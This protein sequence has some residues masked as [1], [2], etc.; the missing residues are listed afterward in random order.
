MRM[1]PELAYLHGKPMSTGI[2]KANQQDF[3]VFEQL[4]FT[5][6]GEGEH[7][8]IH[9]RKTGGNTVF[10]ARALAKYF[11]VKEQLVSYA[12]LKDRFAVTEQWFG[13][14]L[15]GKQTYDLSDLTIEGVEILSYKRHNKKLRTGALTGNR[16]ELVIREVTNLKDLYERWERV[17]REGVPNYFGEQRFGID[18]GNIEAALSLFS[19]TKV[20]DKKK[21]GIY[22][23][24]ARSVIFNDIINERIKHKTFSTLAVGD[25][26]MLSG[27]Q[28][29]FC[30]ENLD[31]VINQ[32]LNNKDIDITASMWG[33]GE[34][35]SAGQTREFEQQIAER[36]SAFSQGLPR[37]GLKQERRRI[38]LSI[39]DPDIKVLPNHSESTSSLPN[40][41]ISF[42]LAAGS[43]ATTV[44]R[45]LID[46]Q[47][48]SVRHN[49][50]NNV[51]S[52]T[53]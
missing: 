42:S 52:K 21:R 31:D 49:V 5:P 35:M 14:H 20:K 1:L 40:V 19:G 11:K 17:V 24:A 10:V 45:E 48:G 50:N 13:V 16:F 4:P 12:G 15:P 29:V 44:L 32:R 47:D 3:C 53:Q 18:G 22:L 37:F 34:L 43:Y 23:S 39:A 27:T 2:L 6:C 33:A 36:Y 51:E 28:S 41:K 7:L 26:V 9:I 46:Y 38:R 30:I 25:V 8:F